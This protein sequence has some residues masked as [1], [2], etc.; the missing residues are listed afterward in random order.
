MDD[1]LPCMDALESLD[2]CWACA[3]VE[4][5]YSPWTR[6]LAGFSAGIPNLEVSHPVCSAHCNLSMAVA[7]SS[8]GEVSSFGW[9]TRLAATNN[10]PIEVLALPN[11]Y[12][13]KPKNYK[14]PSGR[15]RASLQGVIHTVMNPSNIAPNLGDLVVCIKALLTNCRS[16]LISFLASLVDCV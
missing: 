13:A 8:A 10:A 12:I 2:F 14:A 1:R 3:A 6:F 15:K 5:H 16:D 4:M 7:V 9:C 11:D